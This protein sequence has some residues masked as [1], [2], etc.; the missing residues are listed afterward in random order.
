VL[1]SSSDPNA[2]VRPIPAG[3]N[4]T[5]AKIIIQ[6]VRKPAVGLSPRLL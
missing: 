6:P 2:L 3:T 5:Y 4:S 1:A